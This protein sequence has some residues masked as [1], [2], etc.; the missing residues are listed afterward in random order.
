VAVALATVVLVVVEI[1][2][3]VVADAAIVLVAVVMIMVMRNIFSCL[4]HLGSLQ[5]VQINAVTKA[6]HNVC[7]HAST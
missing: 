6:C 1:I 4:P 5:E 3:V 2:M 7:R